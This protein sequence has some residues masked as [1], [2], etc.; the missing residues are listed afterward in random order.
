MGNHKHTSLEKTGDIKNKRRQPLRNTSQPNTPKTSS[1]PIGI[2]DHRNGTMQLKHHHEISGDSSPKVHPNATT[3]NLIQD[4]FDSLWDITHLHHNPH[5]LRPNNFPWQPTF[6]RGNMFPPN[7]PH[8]HASHLMPM[9]DVDNLN[10]CYTSKYSVWQ[11][12]NGIEHGKTTENSSLM[13]SNGKQKIHM[14]YN[15]HRHMPEFITSSSSKIVA[16]DVSI[17]GTWGVSKPSEYVQ[18]LIGVILLALN[19]LK[20]EKIMPTEANIVDCIK[21]GDFKHRNTNVK[22]ALESAIEQQIIVK[23]NLGDLLCYVPKNEKLWNCVNPKGG[24][25]N[26]YPTATWD[27]I[28]RYLSSPTGRLAM[29]ASQCR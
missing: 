9:P 5:L 7:R 13:S 8:T 12:N 23:H 6:P 1:G 15:S 11:Q 16:S 2:Q 4:N 14:Q 10:T 26:D 18:G 17:N 19:T 28:R 22:K 29:R 27:G 24:T 3:P 20:S 21:Y 25:P